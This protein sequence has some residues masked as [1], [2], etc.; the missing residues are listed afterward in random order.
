MNKWLRR[1]FGLYLENR[2][3]LR[4][5]TLEEYLREFDRV[6]RYAEERQ[7]DWTRWDRNQVL[8][9]L[10]DR[11]KDLSPR[12]VVKLL[13]VL[14]NLYAYL[15][16]DKVRE[17]DPMELVEGPRVKPKIPE[18]FEPVEVDRFLA[19]FP[20]D[21]PLHIRDRALFELIYSC[22][23][24][25]SEASEL[26][27]SDVDLENALIRVQG[28]GGKERLVPLT[29]EAQKFLR[30]YLAEARP[31]LA[32]PAC[33][34]VFVNAR[35]EGLGRKG[36]WKNFK[37]G[38][39][40][41]GLEGKVHTLRHSFATHL[42]TGGADLRSVQELLGHSSIATTQIYTHVRQDD[43]ARVHRRYHPGQTQRALRENEHG[44][45]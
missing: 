32:R 4:P 12:S 17:D 37:A 7:T 28:K 19:L 27:L 29:E 44:K 6:Q 3:G 43:L 31:R 24:R 9:Y 20:L 38:L 42:L 33:Q 26:R 45:T 15:I 40:K 35:G 21:G 8:Q 1:G 14:R 2:Q 10:S 36:I 25:V 39:R 13:S 34:E 30:L 41:L 5:R 23:L 16:L 11:T 22:G 18:V